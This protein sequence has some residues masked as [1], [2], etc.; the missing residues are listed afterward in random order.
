MSVI[1]QRAVH[2]QEIFFN[3]P[4]ESQLASGNAGALP[5]EH[6]TG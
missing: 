4:G 2:A 5:G 3:I 1:D 6:R